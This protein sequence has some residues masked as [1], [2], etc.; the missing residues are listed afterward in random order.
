M[1]P[2]LDIP[3]AQA[4]ELLRLQFCARIFR[5]LRPIGFQREIAAVVLK[6]VSSP[7]RAELLQI[8]VEE[9]RHPA[10]VFRSGRVREHLT[11]VENYGFD[12]SCHFASTLIFS[13]RS[14]FSPMN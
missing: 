8:G 6:A 10:P 3:L 1:S 12:L 9:A 2:H 4:L 7:K 11:V 14:L 5:Q 13:R